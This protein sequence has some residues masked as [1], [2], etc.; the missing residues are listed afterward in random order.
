MVVIVVKYMIISSFSFKILPP[1]INFLTPGILNPVAGKVKINVAVTKD[2]TE[3][4]NVVI[5]NVEA[6]YQLVLEAPVVPLEMR[7]DYELST[8][9]WNVTINNRSYLM[10]KPTVANEV[11]VFIN[12]APLCK[13]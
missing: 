6:P 13:V 12:G 7:I 5:N 10:V 8:K 4:V 1:T 2:T 9:V 3:V 11:E